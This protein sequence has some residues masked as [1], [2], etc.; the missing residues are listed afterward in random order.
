MTDTEDFDSLHQ[1]R[2]LGICHGKHDSFESVLPRLIGH[3][4]GAPHRMERAIESYL[5]DDN[6]VFQFIQVVELTRRQENPEGD[7]QIEGSPAFTDIRGRQVDDQFRA[8]HLV[9]VTFNR[10]LDP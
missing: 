6:V 8:R 5:P 2:L 1:R 4:K 9:V 3:A 7:R 10:Y